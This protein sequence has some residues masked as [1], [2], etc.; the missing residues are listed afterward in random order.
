MDV[1]K[2][3][4]TITRVQEQIDKLLEMQSTIDAYTQDGE[5][6]GKVILALKRS[7]NSY[8]GENTKLREKNKLQKEQIEALC[9]E[10]RKIR[11]ER[12][13]LDA[14]YNELQGVQEKLDKFL[15]LPWYKKIFV[16]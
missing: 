5:E 3:K 2:I 10:N 9:N 4:T 11:K 12:N 14:K 1:K 8:K 7:I 15:A 6:M 16:K 13:E